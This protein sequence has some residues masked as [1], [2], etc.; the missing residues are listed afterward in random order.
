MR[1]G[2]R[3]W[4]YLARTIYTVLWW[5]RL[6][7]REKLPE[8]AFLICPNHRS[9]FDPPM[10]AFL[11]PREIGFLAK[12]ELFHNPLFGGLIRYLNARPIRRG[13]IDRTAEQEILRLLASG[14]PVLVFPEGTRSRTGRMQ[15]PR[16]GVGRL[17]R[18]AGLPIVPAYI[19]G[20]RRLSL[21]VFRWRRLTIRTGE[22]IPAEEVLAFPDDK[23]GYR[24]LSRLI[25]QRI[26]AL[27]DDSA[28]DLADAFPSDALVETH[29]S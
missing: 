16:P 15:S 11:V 19:E 27:S 7:G 5:P 10:V 9:W 22:P 2:Y 14:R 26:C 25:M 29:G 17:A 4:L 3:F 6:Q 24:A 20:N 28:R 12:A 8:G 18:I 21:A 1:F 23:D 13:V